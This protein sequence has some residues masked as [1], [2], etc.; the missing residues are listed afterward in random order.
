MG[1]AITFDE[2][3]VT[4]KKFQKIEKALPHNSNWKNYF[5]AAC[6]HFN[7]NIDLEIASKLRPY[8]GLIGTDNSSSENRLKGS[9]IL[10]LHAVL[11]DAAGFVHDHLQLRPGYTYAL[12][13]PN[14]SCYLGHFSGFSHAIIL[15]LTEWIYSV[16][17]NVS[18]ETSCTRL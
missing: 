4:H 2:I 16:S 1:I 14:N 11:H 5:L 10:R 18:F 17:W 15:N 12:P 3:C 7:P 6:L 8:G 13:C 9:K